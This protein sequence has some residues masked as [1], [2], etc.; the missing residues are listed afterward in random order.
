MSVVANAHWS[1]KWVTPG[2]RKT[3]RNQEQETKGENVEHIDNI[4]TKYAR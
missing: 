1:H 3:G 4:L 2:I